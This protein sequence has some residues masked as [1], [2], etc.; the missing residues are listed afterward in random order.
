MIGRRGLK[1]REHAFRRGRVTLSRLHQRVLNDEQRI[2]RCALEC[3][4][5]HGACAGKVADRHT[6]NRLHEAQR[7]R[8]GALR[9]R[10][11]DHALTFAG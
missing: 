10:V 1:S 2:A 5:Q 9:Q 6:G 11:A 7:H 3:R 8:R 4:L